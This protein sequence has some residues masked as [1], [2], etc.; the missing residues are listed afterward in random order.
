M[1]AYPAPISTS[2]AWQHRTGTSKKAIDLYPALAS[3]ARQ[4]S[5]FES[6]RANADF[7]AIIE[8]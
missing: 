1:R 7:S 4:D 8:N 3:E 5:D 6:L 2:V